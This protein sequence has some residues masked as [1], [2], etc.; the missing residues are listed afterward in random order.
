MEAFSCITT[1][2]DR[3]L[4]RVSS[5]SGGVETILAFDG[6][7]SRSMLTKTALEQG[8]FGLA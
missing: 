2:A 5:R 8:F 6:L 4:D 3:W 1:S 7:S